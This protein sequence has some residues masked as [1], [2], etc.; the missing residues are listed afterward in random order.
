MGIVK[1]LKILM[2]YHMEL[3]V[4]TLYVYQ[5]IDGVFHKDVI[6][7]K[8]PKIEKIIKFCFFFTPLTEIR[9]RNNNLFITFLL[10]RVCILMKLKI[11]VFS[12]L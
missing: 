9:T 8:C 5:T 11:V 2:D 10:K 4:Q 6:A 1:L 7:A 12:L 3:L